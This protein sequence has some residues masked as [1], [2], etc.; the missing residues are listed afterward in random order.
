MSPDFNLARFNHEAYWHGMLS[1]A[2][3]MFSSAPFWGMFD[4][5]DEWVIMLA[6][7]I[8]KIM[9]FMILVMIFMVQFGLSIGM[10]NLGREKDDLLNDPISNNWAVW[11]IWL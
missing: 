3:V 1:A 5:F 8:T 2:A 7:S 9:P 6:M 4:A 10:L 11:Q